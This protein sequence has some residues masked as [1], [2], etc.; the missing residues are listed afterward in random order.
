MPHC[1]KC[2]KRGRDCPGYD[3]QKPLQWVEP[4]KITSRK[5]TKPSKRSELI[6]PIMQSRP[7]QIKSSSSNTS[8][9]IYSSG[10][11]DT[12]DVEWYEQEQLRLIYQKAFAGVQHVDE[13]DRILVLE[14]KERIMD[15]LE[16]G[17]EDEAARMLKIEQ[18]PLK[19][20]ERILQYM[21]LEN[22]PNYN[23]LSETSEVV[24]AI[25]Y[26]T[27]RPTLSLNHQDPSF[28]REWATWSPMHFRSTRC[29]MA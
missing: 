24:Q 26:C 9:S 16:R 1:K 21:R 11:G 22:L 19:G 27:C 2:A 28:R 18:N 15:V 5:R 6:I 20:L 12:N 25:Q 29:S 23:L 13:V 7:N 8:A 10:S 3:A 17:A 14:N 4:G